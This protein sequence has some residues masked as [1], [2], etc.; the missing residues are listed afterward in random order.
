[1]RSRQLLPPRPFPGRHC[2][3]PRVRA[4][5][6][7]ACEQAVTF[8]GVSTAWQAVRLVP[9]SCRQGC[10]WRLACP[11]CGRGRGRQGC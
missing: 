11:G 9:A 8:A 2:A 6:P 4:R 5:Q 10:G 7:H 1:M 3:V